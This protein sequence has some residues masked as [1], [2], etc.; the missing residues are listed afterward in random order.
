MSIVIR[1]KRS[2]PLVEQCIFNSSSICVRN[3]ENVKQLLCMKND[4]QFIPMKWKYWWK[5]ALICFRQKFDW[6]ITQIVPISPLLWYIASDLW[7][8][9][10]SEILSF[11]VICVCTEWVEYTF[12]NT[13]TVFNALQVRFLV[14]IMQKYRKLSL[15]L[16]H[17][18]EW[19]KSWLA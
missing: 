6:K 14:E 13:Q 12:W 7:N 8:M 3:K 5:I 11:S 16:C 1:L 19:N 2:Q 17:I 9:S 4:V 10:L 15:S 18:Y